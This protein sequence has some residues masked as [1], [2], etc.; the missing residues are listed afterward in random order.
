MTIT[1]QIKQKALDIGFDL[2]GITDASP[3]EPEYIQHFRNWLSQGMAAEMT[4][5]HNNFEKRINPGELLDNARSVI[6]LGLNY[7]PPKHDRLPTGSAG[8]TGRIANYAQ[9]ED[10]HNF[11]KKLIRRLAEFITRITSEEVNF[12]F[13][14][15]TV[16]IAERALAERAGLGFIG[17][18][19]MLI[20]P[21]LGLQILLAEIVTTAELA[22]DEPSRKSCPDCDL[23]IGACPTGAL[24]NKGRF[25]ARKCISYL[26]IEQKGEIPSGY[27]SKISDELFGCDN[28]LLA[29]PYNN[30]AGQCA[31]TEFRYYPERA[32]INFNQILEMTKKEF[33]ME[34]SDSPILRIGLEKLKQNAHT[35]LK[36]QQG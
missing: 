30:L 31:N 4:Y 6:C 21:K 18:N 16:P 17:K 28:C 25:D 3:I 9:Y 13:C 27:A 33:E 20:N 5:L 10:Y 34:F 26:T 23:C 19:H 14:V 8:R 15:D 36:N 12:K 22:P 7:S 2:A 29:C 1:E 11:L 24:D 35:C 32:R